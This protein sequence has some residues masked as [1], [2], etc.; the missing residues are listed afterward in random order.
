MTWGPT[1]TLVARMQRPLV[2]ADLLQ[3][4][5]GISE[6]WPEAEMLE[7]R[8]PGGALIVDALRDSFIRYRDAGPETCAITALYGVFDAAVSIG[9][10]GE[11]AAQDA[12]AVMI[13][14]LTLEEINGEV[15][16][17]EEA[18]P[19]ILVM[20]SAAIRTF[21]GAHSL[22]PSGLDAKFTAC[23]R[24]AETAAIAAARGDHGALA[25]MLKALTPPFE[26]TTQRNA[27]FNG[28]FRPW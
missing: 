1:V 3:V 22:G 7:M 18:T 20:R 11:E 10:D 24:R 2:R 9:E 15:Q 27:D 13:R 26:W 5:A 25:R 14:L 17:S 6:L 19:R 21:I 12:V 23:L 4:L 8:D 28:L 16:G